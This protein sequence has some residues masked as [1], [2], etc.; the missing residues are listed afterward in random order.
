MSEDE[1]LFLIVEPDARTSEV[2]ERE[3]T[4]RGDRVI[5]RE[6]AEQAHQ[7]VCSEP[8]D[9]VIASTTLAD[10]DG[11]RL[12]G[13][14]R[15]QAEFDAIPVLFISDDTSK[16]RRREGLQSGAEDYLR[17]PFFFEELVLR[18]DALLSKN[19]RLASQSSWKVSEGNLSERSIIDLLTEVEEENLTGTL[20]IARDGRQAVVHF[21][22]GKIVGAV[23]GTLRQKEALLGLVAWPSGEYAFRTVDEEVDIDHDPSE[24]V[25]VGIEPLEPWNEVI[26]ALPQLEGVYRQAGEEVP[27]VVGFDDGDVEAI[28]ELFDG[29]RRL[30]GVVGE[31]APDLVVTLRILGELF[32][33]ECLE[34][35]DGEGELEGPGRGESKPEFARWIDPAGWSAGKHP[36]ADAEFISVGAEVGDE[37]AAEGEEAEE[38]PEGEAGEGESAE[39][40]SAGDSDTDHEDEARK[41]AVEAEAAEW[42][43]ALADT[44]DGSNTEEVVAA[45]TPDADE[46]GGASAEQD[47]EDE[48]GAEESEPEASEEQ[49]GEAD[50]EG[51]EAETSEQGS[52]LQDFAEHDAGTIEHVKL[53]LN[54]E[55]AGASGTFH[56]RKE[57][58]PP[59]ARIE[60]QTPVSEPAEEVEIDEQLTGPAEELPGM[61]GGGDLEP[62]MPGE[63]DSEGDAD[64]SPEE[65]GDDIDVDE[66]SAPAGETRGEPRGEEREG[67]PWPIVVAAVAVVGIGVGLFS[68][69]GGEEGADAED[70]TRQTAS[71]DPTPP[72]GESEE[73]SQAKES[74]DEAKPEPAPEKIAEPKK[75]K[76]VEETRRS[77]RQAA[78]LVKERV[79]AMPEPSEKAEREGDGPLKESA[80]KA[81]KEKGEKQETAPEEEEPPPRKEGESKV[82]QKT[83]DAPAEKA[84]P[85]AVAAKEAEKPSTTKPQPEESSADE[86]SPENQEQA[87]DGGESPQQTDQKAQQQREANTGEEAYKQVASL[88][89]DGSFSRAEQKLQAL[90]TGKISRKQV[91]DLYLDL[92]AGYQTEADNVGAAQRVYEQYLDTYPNGKYA[93]EV[94][95]ILARLKGD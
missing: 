7:V 83:D 15:E 23:S 63:G 24:L 2:L 26:D 85:G 11:F 18:I 79:A 6:S 43:A 3:L 82:A 14:L 76:V 45:A 20:N 52:G 19:C 58:E 87:D 35:A 53:D 44:A 86:S 10:G 4:D 5:A 37:E 12:C 39:T 13:M 94:R 38:E 65:D 70:E 92:A 91:G 78:E 1:R 33:G 50:A 60:P 90:P 29:E 32:D 27:D 31:S 40:S 49:D 68:M 67:S 59:S 81:A 57:Q 8:V 46:S 25:L 88:I 51:S 93:S 30:G 22:N 77:G 42:D 69:G 64:S 62:P 47:G 61:P 9:L 56:E 66:P 16:S 34:E 75:V 74:K 95:S 48:A 73:S 21:E 54:D 84:D 72:S 71:A 28:Y 89:D 36:R 17:K 55:G 80:E 41:M